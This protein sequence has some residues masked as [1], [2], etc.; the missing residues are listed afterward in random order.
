MIYQ[1]FPKKDGTKHNLILLVNVDIV[2]FTSTG[3]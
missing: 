1:L 3:T 2:A